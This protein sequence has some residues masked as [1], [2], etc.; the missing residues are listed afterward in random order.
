MAQKQSDTEYNLLMQNDI[1]T[2]GHT[3]WFFFRVQNTHQNHKVKF[4]ILN[5]SKPD[6][7]FNYGMKVTMYSEKKSEQQKIGWYKGCTD[8]SYY[9]NGIKKDPASVKTYFTLT[10][11]HTF[12]HADDS[13]F[14]AFCYPYTYSDLQE[15]I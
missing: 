8:I 13:V 7:L 1:N 5:F 15:D 12:E 10:F 4:N 14:F 3:Q 11:S 9:S 6:S 2:S